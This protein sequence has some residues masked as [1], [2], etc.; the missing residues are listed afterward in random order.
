MG[1]KH[2][3]LTAIIYNKKNRILSIGKNSYTKTHPIMFKYG[4]K[5]GMIKKIYLHAE[6]AAIIRCENIE[7]AY[8]IE[9]YRTNIKGEYV[10]SKPCPICMEGIRQTPIR[11]LVYF[12]LN[13]IAVEEHI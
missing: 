9:V 1:R 11:K 2:Q 6:I 10:S 12:D 5:L 8:R 7:D 3:N 13:G 4:F